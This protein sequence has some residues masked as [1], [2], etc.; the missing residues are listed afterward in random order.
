MCSSDLSLLLA[1][2]AEGNNSIDL[3]FSRDDAKVAL[4]LALDAIDQPEADPFMDIW[5]EDQQ[6]GIAVGTFGLIKR[7]ENGGKHW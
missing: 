4:E 7:A 1:A 3:E 5:F 2:R 6:H